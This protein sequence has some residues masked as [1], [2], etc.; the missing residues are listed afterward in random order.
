MTAAV[1]ILFARCFDT[2]SEYWS[3]SSTISSERISSMMSAQ[4]KNQVVWQ[5]E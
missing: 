1:V 2:L 4:K 5:H 3:V